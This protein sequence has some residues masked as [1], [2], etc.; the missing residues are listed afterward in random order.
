MLCGV[1]NLIKES[2]FYFNVKAFGFVQSHLFSLFSALH[3]YLSAAVKQTE[4]LPAQN[5]FLTQL[6]ENYEHE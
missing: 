6:R 5:P 2:N 1:C 4:L 3:E